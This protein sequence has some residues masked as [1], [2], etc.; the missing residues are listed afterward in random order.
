MMQKELAKRRK[1]DTVNTVQDVVDLIM[2]SN[3]IMVVTGAGVSAN[4][5]CMSHDNH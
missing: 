3:N 5:D 2:K 4:L 1:L